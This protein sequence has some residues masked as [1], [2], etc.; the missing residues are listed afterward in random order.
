MQTVI[1]GS[2]FSARYLIAAEYSRR[3]SDE[4][5]PERQHNSV[6]RGGPGEGMLI[7]M[8]PETHRL[9]WYGDGSYDRTEEQH[10][11]Y[12]VWDWRVP[13]SEEPDDR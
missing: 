13:E 6:L 11:G 2:S 9:I 4:R 8:A 5:V 10:D 7:Q 12:T 1:G 3:P